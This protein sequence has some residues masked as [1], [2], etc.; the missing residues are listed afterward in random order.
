MIADRAFA[1]RLICLDC[2]APSGSGISRRRN[3]PIKSNRSKI[4]YYI[5]ISIFIIFIIVLFL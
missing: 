3:Y 5:L 1:G 2:G 4:L